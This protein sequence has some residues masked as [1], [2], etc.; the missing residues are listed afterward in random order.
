MFLCI[1]GAKFGGKKIDW[2]VWDR[3][4][5]NAVQRMILVLNYRGKRLWKMGALSVGLLIVRLPL[6]IE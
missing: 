3:C 4:G 2:K 5:I 6:A 1:L